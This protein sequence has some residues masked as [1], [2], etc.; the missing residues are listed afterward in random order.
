MFPPL[1]SDKLNKDDFIGTTFLSLTEISAP[2]EEGKIYMYTTMCICQLQYICTC[3][4]V[5]MYMYLMYVHVN[6]SNYSLHIH[7]HCMYKHLLYVKSIVC[8]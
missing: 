8:I 1:C 3:T 4:Y 7:V 6:Y 5:Y 2:G